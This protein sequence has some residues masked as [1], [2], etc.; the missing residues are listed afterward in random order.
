MLS[1]VEVPKSIEAGM[2]S[3]R[4]VFCRDKGFD[5]VSRYITG[6]VIS[7]N[8]TLQGIYDLQVREEASAKP[9]RRSMHESVFESGRD[10]RALM[11]QHRAFISPSHR[12][13]GREVISL[14]WTFSHHDRG[15]EIYGNKEEY[16]YVEGRTGRFQTLVTAVVSNNRLIDGLD[17]VVQA[18]NVAVSE[19][20]YL[21]MTA[22]DSYEQM[23]EVRD[24]LLELLHHQKHKLEYKKRTEIAYEMVVQIEEEGLFP[25]AHYAFDN[26][27]LTID[28]SHYIESRGKHWVSEIVK[29]H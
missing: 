3:Y 24:R 15:P 19:L 22:R 28:L 18:P 6:L 29:S 13:Q 25:E 11:K 20:E 21:K 17:E 5:H 23:S 2:L 27:V 10:S 14:D 8:K 9:C 1:I 12:G 16:D 7:P 26:G 4:D